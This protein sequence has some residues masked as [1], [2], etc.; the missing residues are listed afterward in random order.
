[1]L[2]EAGRSLSRTLVHVELVSAR[3]EV[4][5]R[6]LEGGDA[7]VAEIL[8]SVAHLAQGVERNLG[9]MNMQSTVVTSIGAVVAA[10]IRA[11]FGGD[12]PPAPP[13]GS[14][15]GCGIGPPASGGVDP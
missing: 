9:T 1:M 14:G 3:V 4:L 5:S 15:D 2:A 12:D 11:R 10:G 13:A 6:G 7:R 8:A